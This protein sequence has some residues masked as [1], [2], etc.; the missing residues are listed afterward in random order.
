MENS[1]EAA[2]APDIYIVG[3]GIKSVQH[4]TLE[5]IDILKTCKTVF[6][7]D[8][9]FGVH[10]FI[11]AL[12]PE[13]VDLIPEYKE[14]QHRLITYQMMA[15]RV[16]DAAMNAPPVAF[17]I[18]GH[19]NWLVFPS[20]LI[21]DAASLLGLTVEAVAGISCIDTVVLELGIDPA[22]HGLQIF[23]ASG[24]V[25]GEVEINPSVPCMILQVDAF[26]TETYSRSRIDCERL[27]SLC[28]YLLRFYPADHEVISVYSSTHALLKPV[29]RRYRIDD[30]QRAFAEDTVS[31]TLY[32]PHLPAG[33]RNGRHGQPKRSGRAPAGRAKSR[34]RS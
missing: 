26:K 18:Y 7:V 1:V 24:L 27:N 19:P 32:V 34:R 16:V 25:I 10:D 30:L 28:D 13:V 9:G 21:T 22:T 33:E 29:I 17:A 2:P 11:R 12:G 8:H 3:L 6:V 5:A 4:L 31:G 15:A 23:E 14:G 20:E